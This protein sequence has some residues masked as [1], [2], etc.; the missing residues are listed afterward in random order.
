MIRN[1]SAI[2]Y[3][4]C[5][6][7]KSAKPL[8][9]KSTEQLKNKTEE[10]SPKKENRDSSISPEE[11]GNHKK[12]SPQ[13]NACDKNSY[14]EV[15][16]T[17]SVVPSNSDMFIGFARSPG[18]VAYRH[19]KHGSHFIQT[20]TTIIND[21]INL[22]TKTENIDFISM[23]TKVAVE[24]AVMSG[25]YWPML[26]KDKAAGISVK[27]P[28]SENGKFQMPWHS[29]TLPEKTGIQGDLSKLGN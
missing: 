26:L 12:S 6:G 28:S 23:M 4:V 5:Q 24:V 8:S 1:F 9:K 15:E 25:G 21:E 27:E 14:R 10:Q 11:E 13:P 22:P 18:F 19:P 17:D 7:N 2:Q 16:D 29:S 3:K 20:F